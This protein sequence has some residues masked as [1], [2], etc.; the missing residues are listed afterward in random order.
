M[1][2][3]LKV[4]TSG[5]ACI[6]GKDIIVKYGRTMHRVKVNID[7]FGRAYAPSSIHTV[8]KTDDELIIMFNFDELERDDGTFRHK[9]SVGI[10]TIRSEED[11]GRTHNAF[12]FRG[13][14]TDV[15]VDGGMISFMHT[16]RTYIATTTAILKKA[17]E[18]YDI[19][20]VDTEGQSKHYV[21]N[22]PEIVESYGRPDDG[23]NET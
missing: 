23:G 7:I 21:W 22:N 18:G 4:S 20:S 3:A 13:D 14:V 12:W 9:G 15:R 16:Y 10:I 2:H 5:L 6:S 1:I 19:N 8:I 11:L 17:L